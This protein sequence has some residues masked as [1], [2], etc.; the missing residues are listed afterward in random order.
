MARKLPRNFPIIFFCEIPWNWIQVNLEYSR[1]HDNVKYV[2]LMMTNYRSRKFVIEPSLEILCLQK[3]SWEQKN[4]F[5]F[6]QVE[7]FIMGLFMTKWSIKC[8]DC[9]LQWKEQQSSVLIRS[10]YPV[11]QLLHV[12]SQFSDFFKCSTK[13]YRFGRDQ[14]DACTHWLKVVNNKKS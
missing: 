2:F 14:L 7:F 1:S 11:M 4:I 8:K 13:I 3:M 9:F 10:W 6:H 12:G 5:V